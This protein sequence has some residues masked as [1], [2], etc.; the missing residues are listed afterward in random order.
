MHEAILHSDTGYTPSV[1]F[2]SGMV[3]GLVGTTASHPFE[4]LRARL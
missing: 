2:F 3:A 4:I 1:T